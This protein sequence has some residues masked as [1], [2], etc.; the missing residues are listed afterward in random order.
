VL[1]LLQFSQSLTWPF[2]SAAC[3][4][5]VLPAKEDN[6]ALIPVIKTV[7]RLLLLLFS[8]L[9]F[10]VFIIFGVVL[11]VVK[12]VLLLVKEYEEEEEE[13]LVVVVL[14][15]L[16]VVVPKEGGETDAL[17]ERQQQELYDM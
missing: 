16:F 7:F 3:E 8:P 5:V 2:N 17:R 14:V 11:L 12:A 10:S 1:L 9:K 4:L 15:L 6:N 13:T